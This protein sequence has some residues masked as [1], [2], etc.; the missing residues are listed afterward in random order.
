MEYCHALLE[1]SN[2]LEHLIFHS[3]DRSDERDRQYNKLRYISLL[4]F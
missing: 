2:K 1:P 4:P 3:H